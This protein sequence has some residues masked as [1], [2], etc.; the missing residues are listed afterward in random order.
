MLKARL[1]PT[2]APSTDGKRYL[3]QTFSVVSQLLTP[4]GYSNITINDNPDYKDHVY[5]YSAYDFLDGKR[6]GPISTYFKTA[7]ARS[8]LVYKDYTK[9]LNV[10]RNGAQ[11]TGVITNNTSIGPNGVVPLTANGR[12]IL[13]AGTFGTSRLLFQS[14]IGPSDMIALVQGD[15]VAGPLLPP[16][17]QWIDLPVGYNVSD[18]PS[19]NL[20]FTQPTIDDY[21]NWA[22][23][24]TDPRPADAAQYIE[25]QS[26]VFSQASPRL[27]FWR[28]YSASDGIT[29][30]LQG[31]AR[32]GAASVTTAYAYNASQ[33]MTITAYLS[34]GI[35]SR[36]RI[37]IDAALTATPIVNPWFTDPV[38][39][40]VLLQGLEDILSTVDSVPGLTLI[41]PDNTTTLTDYVN[42]YPA[43]TLCSNHWVGA[44]SIGN[45]VD[46]NTLVKGTNNLFVIDASIIPSL[47]TGNPHG[48]LMAVA[49][50]A[51]ARVLALAGGP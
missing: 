20:V 28:A 8:N 46:E 13:S 7:I 34:T 45:V 27:N 33:L 2:D 25:N 1:P 39:K 29:R 19:I 14:G 41:T 35:T 30:Y 49:E 5:G 9:V 40:Q 24:M 43:A 15:P 6:A 32:P 37:G 31:T 16:E 50:Q 48:L 11:I 36:G 12:V 21:D 47:P 42:S 18:N 44:C 3:E 10:V 23:V 22:D 26:G 17:S 38:D 51:V 4:Q